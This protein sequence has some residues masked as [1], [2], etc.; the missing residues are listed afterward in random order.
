M[1]L[2]ELSSSLLLSLAPALWGGGASPV[3]GEAN[4]RSLIDAPK[5]NGGRGFAGEVWRRVLVAVERSEV[6]CRSVVCEGG[7]SA[8][9]GGGGGMLLA[10]AV[11][12]E[13][14]ML[15]CGGTMD[16]WADSHPARQC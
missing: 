14:L 9:V 4:G 2:E 7:T 16:G 5:A 3:V 10:W 12:E 15:R 6:M 13:R 11:E 8:G 1:L